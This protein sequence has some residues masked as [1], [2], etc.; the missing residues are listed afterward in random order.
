MALQAR[1]RSGGQAQQMF[2]IAF[3]LGFCS[4]R[5]GNGK[6]VGGGLALTWP[7][8]PRALRTKLGMAWTSVFAAMIALRLVL[9]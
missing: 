9:A 1:N 2:Q 6:L 8:M 5:S 3:T 4:R 7:S